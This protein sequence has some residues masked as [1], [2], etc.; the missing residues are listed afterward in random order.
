MY[1][2]VLGC[3]CL[4]EIYYFDADLVGDSGNVAIIKN[5]ICMH[6]EDVGLGWKHTGKH[7][8]S[9]LPRP[10]IAASYNDPSSYQYDFTIV[11][12]ILCSV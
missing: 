10:T 7:A 8:L 5:A 6:E 12:Q 11:I 9:L 3:D 2:Q 1:I 4:G